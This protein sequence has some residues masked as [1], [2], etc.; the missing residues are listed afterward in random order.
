MWWRVF[1]YLNQASLIAGVLFT[2]R[3]YFDTFL[4]DIII[5]LYGL[6]VLY[7]LIL[8]IDRDFAEKINNFVWVG[9]FIAIVILSLTIYKCSRK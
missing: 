4:I 7:N 2:M 9:I 8:A 5:G 1:Y 6:R 3:G